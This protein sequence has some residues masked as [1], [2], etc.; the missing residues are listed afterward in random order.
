ML[1]TGVDLVDNQPKKWKIENTWGENFGKNGQY[2]ATNDWLNRYVFKICINK[3][4]LTDRQ[5]NL[6]NKPPILV[7]KW[8]EKF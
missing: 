1:I 4:Y 5:L 3:K 6:L 8:D 2:V 7:R